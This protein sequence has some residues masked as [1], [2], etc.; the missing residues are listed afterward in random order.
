MFDL[1]LNNFIAGGQGVEPRSAAPKTDVLP[2]NDPP[3]YFHLT[4]VAGYNLATNELIN[5]YTT[6]DYAILK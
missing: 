3:K 6:I 2:L 4:F 1:P 5:S